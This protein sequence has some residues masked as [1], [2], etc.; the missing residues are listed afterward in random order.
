MYPRAPKV[1][2][3]VRELEILFQQI[4]SINPNINLALVMDRWLASNHLFA[5]FENYKDIDPE[6]YQEAKARKTIRCR[7][8]KVRLSTGEAEYLISNLDKQEFTKK[9]L[10]KLYGL[11]WQIEL[12]CHTLRESLKIEA[13]TSSKP[14]LIKQDIYSGML[15]FNTLQSFI[16]DS[17]CIIDQS[18]YLHRMKINTN[19]AAGFFKKYFILAIIE[20]GTPKA[21]YYLDQ[22]RIH[23]EKCLEP[24][25][26]GRQYER[27]KDKKNKYSINKR[28]AF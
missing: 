10:K 28:K 22:M 23:M 6:F 8:T 2:P 27:K 16:N 5:L 17:N 24:I 9:E 7:I 21:S 13:I 15:A 1:K 4:E 26:G 20:M 19:I 12:N 3:L 11:R 25:R 14:E 18:K